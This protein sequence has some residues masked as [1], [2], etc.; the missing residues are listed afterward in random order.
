MRLT[1]HCIDLNYKRM[2]AL[3]S[4]TSSPRSL[5]RALV[6]VMVLILTA[7]ALTGCQALREISQLRNVDF[8]ID[9][10]ADARLADIELSRIQN[11]D[12]LGLT[13]LARLGR[14]VNRGELPFSFS[15]VIEGTNPEDNPVNAR[16]TELDWTLFLNDRQTIAGSF[17]EETVFRP[18]EPTPIRF[19]IE[20]N[21]VEFFDDGARDLV[22]LALSVAGEG[23]PSNI[24]FQAQP[25]IQTSM[26]PIRYPDPITI[27]HRDVGGTR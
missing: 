11:P 25:T 3:L 22:N 27:V 23:D 12:D 18:G 13:D 24:R 14:A 19:P 10:V 21:L 4:C 2:Y 1:F 20:L 26:G 15:V 17:G 16:M 5:W 6:P 7:T 8:R 9:R